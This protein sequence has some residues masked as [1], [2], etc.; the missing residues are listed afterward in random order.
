VGRVPD[1]IGVGRS[2]FE[3]EIAGPLLDDDE[4]LNLIRVGGVDGLA[5]S[6][7][8]GA[9]LHGVAMLQ[10]HVT[11]FPGMCSVMLAKSDSRTT[12]AH[13]AGGEGAF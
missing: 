12:C 3:V 7:D 13:L 10:G 2:G 6:E 9:G 11:T 1:D 4:T 8:F 5:G